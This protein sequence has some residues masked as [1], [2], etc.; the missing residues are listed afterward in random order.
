VDTDTE[1]KILQNLKENRR[2]KTTILIAHRISTLQQADQILVLEDGRGAEL[3]S[4]E[5]LLAQ[6][7]LYAG[8]YRKQQL[9]KQLE[10]EGGDVQ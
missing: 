10:K 6:N 8:V 3:G 1:E 4:H 7:G 2:G 5:E 9:E